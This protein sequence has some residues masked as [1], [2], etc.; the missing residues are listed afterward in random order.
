[1]RIVRK[2][3]FQLTLAGYRQTPHRAGVEHEPRV[4]IHL[5]AH[6][7][8]W[9][10]AAVAFALVAFGVAAVMIGDAVQYLTRLK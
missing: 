10:W 9:V 2:C 3:D 7:P 4:T 6:I 8:T 5:T 1:M